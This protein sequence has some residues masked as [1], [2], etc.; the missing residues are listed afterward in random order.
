MACCAS[1]SMQGRSASASAVSAMNADS[2][3]L[4]SWSGAGDCLLLLSLPLLHLGLP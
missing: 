1:V 2:I 4:E 3:V